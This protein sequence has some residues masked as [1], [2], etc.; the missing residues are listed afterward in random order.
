MK[1]MLIKMMTILSIF[2]PMMK[3]PLSLGAVLMAQTIL[4]TMLMNKMLL[5]SWFPMITFLMMIGGMMILFMYMSS[6]AS[7]EKFK[8][9]MNLT[10]IFVT[11]MIATEELMMETQINEA[12]DMIYISNQE[13]I[14]MTKLYNK[15]SYIIT[16]L[17]V[18]TLLLT[19]ISI[20]NIV[21]F[22]KGPLRMKTYE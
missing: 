11:M 21:M 20:S 15:K 17:L 16:L 7:N 9:N 8:M 12:Q 13:S 22:H 14:S 19:M 10:M 4:S 3:T 18:L 2:M 6:I 1:F 5:N